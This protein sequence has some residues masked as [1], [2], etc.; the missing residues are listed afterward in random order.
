MSL[1]DLDAF[2]GSSGDSYHV[3][4]K[5]DVLVVSTYVLVVSTRGHLKVSF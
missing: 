2:V 5:Q 3:P 1:L 4:L